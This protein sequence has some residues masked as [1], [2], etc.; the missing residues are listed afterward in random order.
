MHGKES[1]RHRGFPAGAAALAL[2]LGGGPA[3]AADPS[4]VDAGLRGE[5]TRVLVLGS[6]HLAQDGAPVPDAAALAPLLAKLAAFA[7]DV[8][9]IEA[10]PGETCD[11]MRRHAAAYDAAGI[12]R[13]C[14]DT[15]AARA[16]TGLDVPA[17]LAAVDA[18]LAAWPA[19]PTPAQRR[20]LAA[21][22]LAA[23]DPASAAVQWLHLPAG[24]R[25]AGDG[26]DDALVAVLRRRVAGDGETARIAVPLAVRLGLQRVHPVDDHT[27]D[28]L[29][30]DDLD[31][32]AAALR[33]A[34]DGGPPGCRGRNDRARALLAAGEVLAMYRH[35]NGDAYQADVLRCDFGQ[36]MAEPSPQRFGRIYVGGW[37]ARNLRMVANV[38]TTFRDRP[39]TRVLA[40]VGASHKPWFDDWLGRVQGVEPVE[41]SQVLD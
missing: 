23:G 17:A 31:G 26:L 8:V 30:V 22:F 11:L 37:D 25:R 34:W 36:A 21:K 35:V 19:A 24:E 10:M 4:T 38:V 7:P 13:F 39:G 2:L 6:M 29:G 1:M 15:A 5:P 16:A 14:P 27:G 3:A 28:N 9:A 40:L 20:D 32:F 18:A 12:D 41:V 33:A